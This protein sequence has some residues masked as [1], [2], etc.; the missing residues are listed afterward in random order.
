MP[1]G[2]KKGPIGQG[3]MTGRA[4]GYCVG[5]DVPGYMEDRSGLGLA[6]GFRGGRNAGMGRGLGRGMGRQM[7][8]PN[9]APHE[10]NLAP[11]KDEER[12]YLSKQAERLKRTLNEVE[13]RINELDKE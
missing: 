7:S 2:D 11:T 5:N 3:P 9:A 4:M 10:G 12:N 1:R 13:Q 6:R 8:M